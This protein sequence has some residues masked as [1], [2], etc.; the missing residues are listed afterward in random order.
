GTLRKTEFALSNPVLFGR[1]HAAVFAVGEQILDVNINADGL[2]GWR[3]R[4]R[5]GQFTAKASVPLASGAAKAHGFDQAFYRAIPTHANPAHAKYLQTP[6]V[7]FDPGA[8]VFEPK[9]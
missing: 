4:Q 7:D 9:A 5:I 2:A 8:V 1:L 3:Q 6:P